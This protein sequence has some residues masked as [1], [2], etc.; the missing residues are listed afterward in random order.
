MNSLRNKLILFTFFLSGT[1]ALMYEVIWTRPLSL[2]FGTTTY[3]IS[4][5]LAAFMAGLSLGSFIGSKYAD[6][7]KNPL[8]AFSLIEIAIGTYGLAI[9]YIFNFLPS[10]YL[11]VFE[12]FNPDF[13]V[14]SI[15]QFAIIFLVLLIPTTLMGASWPLVNKA[16]VKDIDSVGKRTGTLYTANTAGAIIGPLLAGFVLMPVIGIQASIIIAALLNLISGSI[17]YL[18]LEMFHE[19]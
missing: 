10:I 5:I 16:F 9:I 15:I 12:A 19:L 7:V 11:W 8:L 17:I 6:K 4:T 14:F 18:Y 3:A 2:I 13:F 1:A